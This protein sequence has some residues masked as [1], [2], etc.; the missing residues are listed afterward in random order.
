MMSKFKEHSFAEFF[1]TD[2]YKLN[3]MMFPN[4]NYVYIMIEKIESDSK[5]ISVFNSIQCH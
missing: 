2:L 1:K 4:M 3:T 5:H